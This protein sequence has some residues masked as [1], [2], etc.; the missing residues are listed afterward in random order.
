[1]DFRFW[2]LDWKGGQERQGA[3]IS[4]VTKGRGSFPGGELSVEGTSCVRLKLAV[5]RDAV[6]QGDSRVRLRYGENVRLSAERRARR[7]EFKDT[8]IFKVRGES[9][10][11]ESSIGRGPWL[12]A[13]IH[14][15]VS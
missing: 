9:E 14:F 10:S 1:L 12:K 4:H 13:D 2:I 15:P 8:A 3:K 11:V 6:E 5:L 7:Q